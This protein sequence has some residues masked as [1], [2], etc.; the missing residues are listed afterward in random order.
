[1]IK[2]WVDDVREIP[3]DYGIWEKTVLGTFDILEICYRHRIPVKLSLDH[4]SGV[5]SVNGG[6]YVIW[7]SRGSV[8]NGQEGLSRRFTV[9]TFF[10][11]GLGTR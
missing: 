5:Y 3:E 10:R 6:D 8:C 4:D 1:M 2:I 11:R 9:R 7:R